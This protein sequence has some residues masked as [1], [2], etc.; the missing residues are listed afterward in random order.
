MARYQLVQLDR[1]P[2][3]DCPCGTTRRAFAAEGS[4]A[5]LHLVESFGEARA[6]YH[7]KLTEI[8]LVLEGEGFLELDGERVAVKPF[9]AVL[10]PPGCRHRA[11]GKLKFLNL[12]VP[13]FDPRDEWFD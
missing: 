13:A 3:V 2:A 8:Y 12:P 5:S 6:H 1:I 11:L 9:T 10:I 7:R 4:V